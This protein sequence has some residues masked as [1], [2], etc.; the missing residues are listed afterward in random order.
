MHA[1]LHWLETIYVAER[2]FYIAPSHFLVHGPVFF[3]SLFWVKEENWTFFL[4]VLAKLTVVCSVNEHDLQPVNVH[5]NPNALRTRKHPLML[6]SE[7]NR[8]SSPGWSVQFA[9]G[10]W[11]EVDNLDIPPSSFNKLLINSPALDVAHA[12]HAWVFLAQAG[13]WIWPR[14]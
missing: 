8:I 9:W 12:C 1:T 4:K 11:F 10:W 5:S 3:L 6:A 13:E 14:I 2:S 7:I